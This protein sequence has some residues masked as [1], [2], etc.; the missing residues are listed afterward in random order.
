M[1]TPRGTG[2]VRVL[3]LALLLAVIG[4]AAGGVVHAATASAGGPSPAPGQAGPSLEAERGRA[5]KASRDGGTAGAGGPLGAGIP[6]TVPSPSTGGAVQRRD[7]GR[8]TLILP[9]SSWQARLIPAGWRDNL[10]PSTL[11]RRLLRS[12]NGSCPGGVAS[13]ACCCVT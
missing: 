10:V 6:P 7:V 9:G 13:V 5:P 11:R 3:A 1:R 4:A 2:A 8:L 12:C